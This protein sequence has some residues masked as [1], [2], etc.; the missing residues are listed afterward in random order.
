MSTSTHDAIGDALTTRRRGA[1]PV[2]VMTLMR[3]VERGIPVSVLDRVT[4]EVA[5]NDA[6]FVFRIIPKATLARRRKA[7]TLHDTAKAVL[8]QE[9]GG[10][11]ARVAEV[12]ASALDVWGSAEAARAFLF[13]PHPL[14]EG[15]RPMDV[16]LANEFGRP[17]VLNILGQLK[18]GTAV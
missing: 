6:N 15:E 14:L 1:G 7:D 18:H 2:P 3:Q 4:R 10:R 11:V 13:R 5:P 8:S 9:E 17:V 16:V 12:W